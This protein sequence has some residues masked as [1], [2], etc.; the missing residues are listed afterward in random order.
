MSKLS[1]IRERQVIAMDKMYLRELIRRQDK[2]FNE[3]N[4]Q[5]GF[6]LEELIKKEQEFLGLTKKK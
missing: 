5:E 6:R 4:T 1:N 2:A 3:G